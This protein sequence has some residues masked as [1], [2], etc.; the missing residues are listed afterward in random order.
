VRQLFRNRDLRLLLA[1]ESL[2]MFGDRAMFLVLG[3]WARS[4]TGSNAAAGLVFFAF[5]AP[6][7]LAPLSGLLVDRVR[8]RPLMIVVDCAIGSVMFLLF[9]VHGRGDVWLI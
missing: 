2:S 4:L 8:R 6:F 5:G 7:L 9:L 3:I 1:G